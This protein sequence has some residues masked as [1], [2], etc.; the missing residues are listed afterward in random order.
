MK[1]EIDSKGNVMY[2][3]KDDLWFLKKKMRV[4]ERWWQQPKAIELRSNY[5]D[6][7]VQQY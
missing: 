1:Q 3:E 6:S 5:A 7:Q 2:M 4:V